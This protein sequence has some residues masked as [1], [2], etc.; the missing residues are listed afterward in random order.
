MLA[1]GLR[2]RGAGIGGHASTGSGIL[3]GVGGSQGPTAGAL[4]DAGAELSVG[5]TVG[6]ELSDDDE[7]SVGALDGT[8]HELSVGALDGTNHEV[9]RSWSAAWQSGHFKQSRD[10]RAARR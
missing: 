2:G 1:G 8:N 7:L 6:N 5:A 9:R 4:D 10:G 3:L